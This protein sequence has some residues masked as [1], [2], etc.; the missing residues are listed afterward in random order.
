M[1][2]TECFA[3]CDAPPAAVR[4]SRFE[5]V[6]AT[7]ERAAVTEASLSYQAVSDGGCSTGRSERDDDGW[8]QTTG[9]SRTRAR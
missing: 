3:R 1:V 6:T 5:I 2:W 9:V 8:R 7:G 4:W